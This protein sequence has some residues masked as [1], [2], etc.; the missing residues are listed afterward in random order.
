M[1]K[2]VSTRLETTILSNLIY[3]EDYARKVIPFIKEEYFQDGI[4]KVL[5]TSIWKY[6]ENYKSAATVA[7]L[8]IE[9]QKATLNEEQY[10][11][12]IEYLQNT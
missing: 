2:S 3:N 10:N 12:A 6:A 1:T 7:A 9:V 5:Y 11:T 4:E 8:A